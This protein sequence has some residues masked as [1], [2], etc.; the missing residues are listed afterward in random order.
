MHISGSNKFDMAQA[1]LLAVI[2]GELSR[3]GAQ[4]VYFR[5]GA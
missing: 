5:R 2:V 1:I 3:L 4:I